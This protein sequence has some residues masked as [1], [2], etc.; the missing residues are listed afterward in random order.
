M[1]D[2][3]EINWGSVAELITCFLACLAIVLSYIEYRNHKKRERINILTQLS[4]RYTT[5]LNICSVIK[6][7][8][9]L[10][11]KKENIELPDIHQIEMFMR[12]FEEVDCLIKTKSIKDNVVC[13]MFGHYVL[14]FAENIDK[15]PAELEYN[16]GFWALFRDFVE[17]MKIAKNKKPL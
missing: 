3:C 11:D 7:L 5:D 14:L 6:Y 8:E 10:E 1:I 15:M 4:V 13:Y 9:S 2:F 16:K 12:F 17:R